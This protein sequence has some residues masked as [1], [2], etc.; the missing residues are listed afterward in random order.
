MLPCHRGLAPPMA[1]AHPSECVVVASSSPQRRRTR[2]GIS[3]ASPRSHQNNMDAIFRAAFT[4][5]CQTGRHP[6]WHLRTE[7]RHGLAGTG[8]RSLSFFLFSP[9][10]LAPRLVPTRS[11][12]FEHTQLVRIEFVGTTVL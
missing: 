11:P 8:I 7:W 3:P 6:S 9:S 12:S 2:G 5:L 10:S 1:A 4:S